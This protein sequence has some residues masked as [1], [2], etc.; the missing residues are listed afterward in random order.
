MV[1]RRSV[2]AVIA[3]CLLSVFILIKSIFYPRLAPVPT[4]VTPASIASTA[5]RMA[6]SAEFVSKNGS[7]LRS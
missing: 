3:Q 6:E 1:N 2:L 4:L 5:R 7:V